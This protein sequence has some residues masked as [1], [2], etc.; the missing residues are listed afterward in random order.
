MGRKRRG[1]ENPRPGVDEIEN[2]GELINNRT[3][4]SDPTPG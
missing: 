4:L 2:L 3:S 1:H